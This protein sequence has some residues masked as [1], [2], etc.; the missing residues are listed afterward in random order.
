[1]SRFNDEFSIISRTGKLI[2]FLVWLVLTAG[3]YTLF[4]TVGKPG[5]PPFWFRVYLCLIVPIP[6]SIFALVVAYI[7]ADAK[8]RGMRYVM[9]TWLSILVPNAIGIILYF[10]FREP[11]LAPCAK[12]G[13]MAKRTFAFCPSCGEALQPACPS[14][15]R[16]VEAQWANCAYCGARLAA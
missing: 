14:C 11:L 12:C 4:A 13:A 9:W 8:R 5:D 16:A 2:A 15:R 3:L 7:N 1:M 10:I 6:L